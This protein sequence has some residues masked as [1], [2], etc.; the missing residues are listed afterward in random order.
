MKKLILSTAIILGGLTAATAQTDKEATAMTAQK[1]TA[2]EVAVENRLDAAQ[3]VEVDA[4]A[5]TAVQADAAAALVVAPTQD[6]KEV[7]TSEIPQNIQDAVV[8]DF[9]GAT[10]SKA[11]LNAKGDYKIEIATADAKSATVYANAQGEW[12]KKE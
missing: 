8:N 9:N 6:Y 10:I 12:I 1:Q 2:V 7:K 4:E 3:D 11:Y 5:A